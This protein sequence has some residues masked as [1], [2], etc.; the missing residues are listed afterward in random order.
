MKPDQPQ[1][2]VMEFSNTCG[3][4]GQCEQGKKRQIGLLQQNAWL[5]LFNLCDFRASSL[6]SLSRSSE[7]DA[8]AKHL[9]MSLLLPPLPPRN[10]LN[11]VWVSFLSKGRNLY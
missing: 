4:M 3:N 10:Y 5:P 1:S 11:G 8:D 2:Q 9:D 7:E 6:D